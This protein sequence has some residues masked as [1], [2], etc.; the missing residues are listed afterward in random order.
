MKTSVR[1]T[2]IGA[3][4][5]ALMVLSPYSTPPAHA[6]APPGTE[7]HLNSS[8]VQVVHNTPAN[9][10]V[11][12]MSL[13][14]TNDGDGLG[15]CDLDADDL[16]ETGVHI[17]VSRFSCFAYG[18][19]CGAATC[20]TFDFDAQVNYVEHEIGSAAYG[21]SFAPNASGSVASKIVAVATPLFTCGTWTIN[22]QAT[23]QNLSG[24]TG[25]PVS[26][27]LNDSDN[28]GAGG[29]D[30]GSGPVC[31]DVSANVGNGIVKPHHGVRKARRH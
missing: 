31:F 20:P 27:F 7:I 23:G 30:A 28:D 12:N 25:T 18:F 22:L 19:I 3:V 6:L 24:I 14:V 26:I 9:T 5:G 2:L 21:T 4:A 11:L 10:D 16:L 1:I 13:N 15:S 8:N 29:L 17:S